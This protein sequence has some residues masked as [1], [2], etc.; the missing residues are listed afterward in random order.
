MCRLRGSVLVRSP[1]FSGKTSLRVLV[2]NWCLK[3]QPALRVFHV[4]LLPFRL[5]APAAEIQWNDDW[6]T[7]VY[8]AGKRLQTTDWFAMLKL[9]TLETPVLVIVDEAQL[10]YRFASDFPLWKLVKDAM[11]ASV[12][13]SFLLLAA[14]NVSQA[15]GQSTPVQFSAQHILHFDRMRLR[16]EE[17]KHIFDGT[18]QLGYPLGHIMEDEGASPVRSDDDKH[19]IPCYQQS[20]ARGS[21][22]QAAS[23]L[24]SCG[25]ISPRF[26]PS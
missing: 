6:K 7:W 24:A 1:P 21:P 10:A 23:T 26:S 18:K 19:L 12:G 8:E 5:E 16:S 9:A 17:R 13:L 20:F 15:L 25:S 22:M 3:H 4:S 2:A 14:A 11:G